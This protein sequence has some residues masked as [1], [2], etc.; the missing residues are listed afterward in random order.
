MGGDA[1]VDYRFGY[2][3]LVNDAA[4]SSLVETVAREVV[5]DSFSSGDLSV[6][7]EDMAYFLQRA[8][9]CY[10]GV[11][12]ANEARGLT[13]GN[14]QPRFDIDEPARIPTELPLLRASLGRQRMTAEGAPVRTY[15][16]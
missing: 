6:A 8:P 9:G 10:V 1:R 2:P 15:G 5:G 11:G 16:G 7:S 12:T 3:P 4:M 14:H 13:A